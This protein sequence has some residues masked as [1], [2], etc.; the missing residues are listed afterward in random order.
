MRSIFW[1]IVFAAS[2]FAACAHAQQATHRS[3]EELIAELGDDDVK[4]NAT[5]AIDAIMAYPTSP[6]ERLFV[7]LDDPDWQTRQIACNLIWNIRTAHEPIESKN[8]MFR[9]SA[10]RWQIKTTD[11]QW[12][13]TDIPAVTDRLV[14][15][16]IE[17]FRDDDTPYERS[18]NRALMYTNAVHGMFRIIPIAHQW[19]DE[20]ERAMESDDA[21]QRLVAAIV[22]AQAGVEQSIERVCQILLP[23]LRDNDIEEDA[24]FCV[25][26]LTGYGKELIPVLKRALPDADSQ[27]HDL[28]TLLMLDLVDPPKTK[29]ERIERSRYNSITNI[30]HDPVAEPPFGSTWSWCSMLSD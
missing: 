27:Q 4:N 23:H 6:V 26:A 13:S 29:A 14:A 2:V 11:P 15:V 10:W 30:V 25:W 28:L 7:A 1:L 3:L 9:T 5:G 24:K 19:R 8:D 16:T 12:R 20:L 18:K 21:Q 17:G 22:L